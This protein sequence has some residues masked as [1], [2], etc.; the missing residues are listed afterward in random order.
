[1]KEEQI[2]IDSLNEKTKEQS[3][4]T[5]KS[6]ET[7]DISL[8]GKYFGSQ[9]KKKHVDYQMNFKFKAHIK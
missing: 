8:A 7:T 3:I 2:A 6:G 4:T 9:D 5:L 1:M